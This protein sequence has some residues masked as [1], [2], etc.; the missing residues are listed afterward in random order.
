L[1]DDILADRGQGHREQN[2]KGQNPHFALSRAPGW[3]R[4]TVGWATVW[5]S[6]PSRAAY[7][8]R[9]PSPGR[10]HGAGSSRAV[11]GFPRGYISPNF[12]VLTSNIPAR[13]HR[14]PTHGRRERY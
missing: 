14:T 2:S 5:E 8:S 10:S 13:E 1:A 9:T 7:W 6:N 12:K 11:S 4:G 3:P